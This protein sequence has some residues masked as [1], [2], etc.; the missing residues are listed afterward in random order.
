[1][2]LPG[3]AADKFGNLYEGCWTVRYLLYVMDEKYNS[4]RLE[5]PSPEGEGFEFTV[6][7][8]NTV[9]YH[10]VKS[11]DGWTI[12]RL[13]RNDVLMNFSRNL[14][15][16]GVHCVFTSP[17]PARDLRDLAE[18]ARNS[19]N[20]DEFRAR[21]FFTDNIEK[22]FRQYRQN[23]PGLSEQE[24]Y[25]QLRR[26]WV[27]NVSHRY[28]RDQVRDYAFTLVDGEPENAVDVLA[29]F[30]MNSGVRHS[31][32]TALDLWNHLESREFTR[33]SWDKDPRVLSAVRTA[34]QRYLDSFRSQNISGEVLPRDEVP[35]VG[36]M[37]RADDNKASV[38]LTGL[39]GVG[40][41]G[42]MSQ[43]VDGL[44]EAGLPV[45]AFRVDRLNTAQLPEDVG[46]Q[47]GLPGSPAR[48]LAAVAQGKPSVL[49]IDQLDAVSLASGRNFGLFDCISE[50]L[51]QAQAYDKMG[52]LIACR[53]FDLDN[54]V[55]L[56]RLASR[57]HN[58]NTVTVSGLSEAA[59]R[60]VVSALG[61]NPDQLG[62]RQV[63]LLSVPPA[64]EVVVR[65]CL[66]RRNQG[67]K[68]RKC[69]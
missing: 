19:L 47:F 27:E 57:G 20:L 26:I 23:V 40:K 29:E 59:I 22:A 31:E 16:P 15:Q 54:D 45:V 14:R 38:L 41:T 56:G 65:P 13:T 69:E 4:I 67:I 62:R 60:E 68:L 46:K 30:G 12:N 1:M 33:R 63:D 39:A 37:L 53:K 55:R 44:L 24:A 2:T 50:I 5:D 58:H 8:G 21:P 25:E 61:L 36:D 18:R 32:L 51:S 7:K 66:G 6:K 11:S 10:Q 49:V 42:V 35:V 3:G 34:N 17:D 43:V 9:E 52:I 28:L 48:V 64:F